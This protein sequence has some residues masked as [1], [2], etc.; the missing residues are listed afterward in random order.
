MARRRVYV[1]QVFVL[2]GTGEDQFFCYKEVCQ[3]KLQSTLF[4]VLSRSSKSNGGGTYP[5]ANLPESLA[6]YREQQARFPN[7][8]SSYD[9]VV[10]A[11][12]IL[13]GRTT[14]NQSP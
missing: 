12:T 3:R 5:I 2:Q 6:F 7:H 4:Q 14:D 1:R 13:S 11:L 9:D 8:A 10:A